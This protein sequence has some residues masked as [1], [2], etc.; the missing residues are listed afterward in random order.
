MLRRYA[1]EVHTNG[2]ERIYMAA[3]VSG[4]HW[5]AVCIDFKEKC[6]KYGA[7]SLLTASAWRIVMR[8]LQGWLKQAF[9]MKFCNGGNSLACGQQLDSNSCGICTINA[10]EHNLFDMEKFT[11][12]K[13]RYWRI[14]YFICLSKAHNDYS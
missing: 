9:N 14:H 6:I 12:A 4:N 8:N 10:I 3:F 2:R 13:R 1:Q 7:D 5:I 11:H